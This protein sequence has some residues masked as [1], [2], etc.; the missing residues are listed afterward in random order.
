MLRVNKN[1]EPNFILEFKKKNTP[2]TWN[3]YNDGF[4][5]SEIKAFILEHEQSKYCPY[6]E[7]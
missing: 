1:K 3:D 5:K 2:K 4:I 7:K 6:C